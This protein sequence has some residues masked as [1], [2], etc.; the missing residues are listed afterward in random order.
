MGIS[1]SQGGGGTAA[2]VLDEAIAVA[3]NDSTLNFTGAGVTATQDGGDPNQVNIDIPGVA[4]GDHGVLVGLGDDDHTQYLL[5]DGTRALTGPMDFG[6]AAHTNAESFALAN[7]ACSGIFRALVNAIEIG[8][9]SAHS[10]RLMVS[11]AKKFQIN[12]SVMELTNVGVR[13]EYVAY[14]AGNDTLAVTQSIVGKT[15]ITGGGDTMTLPAPA[16]A[17]AGWICSITDESGGAGT[18][19]ITVDVS[20]GANI[21]G[22]AS[23]DITED[24][25]TLNVYSNGSEYFIR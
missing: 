10:V 24:Y 1:Q 17:G 14:G 11:N 2:E 6:G 7:A 22:Q 3:G 18:D 23:V 25:G 5:A 15:G 20:G 13:H 16:T 8:A 21:S 19:H 4:G 9:V 12:A